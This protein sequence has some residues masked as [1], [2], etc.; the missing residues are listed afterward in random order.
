MGQ[1]VLWST[2]AG[3]GT[4]LGASLVIWGEVPQAIRAF[5]FGL[6]A[7]VMVGVVALDLLP[8]ALTQGNSQQVG[9]GLGGGILAIY[10]LSR[11]L[12]A[13]AVTAGSSRRL[14]LSGYLIATAIAMH[15]FPE[16]LAIGAGAV[17][18]PRL[19]LTIAVAI[20]I[21]DIPEG[22]SL[23]L[24]LRMGGMA[25]WLV[26]ATATGAGLFTTAGAVAGWIFAT[27]AR[28]YVG[29]WLSLAAGAMVYVVCQEVWPA[30]TGS[31]RLG[32]WLGGMT[33]AALAVV[34]TLME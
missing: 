33:G 6:S 4:A 21:H 9:L 18:F 20:G 3:L 30:A 34:L 1:V 22:M 14:L 17:A 7:G 15:N 8:P 32:G 19:G 27:M 11:L 23:G 16:G 29:L 26:L 25:P 13:E 5:L 24:P 28:R 12:A 10:G 2:I 31:N